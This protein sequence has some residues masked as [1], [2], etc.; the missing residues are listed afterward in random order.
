MEKNEVLT[1]TTLINLLD[2]YYGNIDFTTA[3]VKT[4]FKDDSRRQWNAYK[5]KINVWHILP[6]SFEV[7]DKKLER[8]LNNYRLQKRK[9]FLL[10]PLMPLY[11]Y[12]ED[13]PKLD[14]PVKCNFFNLFGCGKKCKTRKNKKGRKKYLNYT[15]KYRKKNKQF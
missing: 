1:H 14:E 8:D 2:K 3:S 6:H 10:E 13:L 4:C 7:I 5:D 15:K 12:E 9:N 11:Y